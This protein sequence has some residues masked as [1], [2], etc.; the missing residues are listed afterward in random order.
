MKVVPENKKSNVGCWAAEELLA[1]WLWVDSI[2]A[3]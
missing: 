3:L 2:L 1:E